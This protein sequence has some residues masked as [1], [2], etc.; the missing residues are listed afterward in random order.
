M[1]KE[2]YKAL[3]DAD[4]ERNLEITR[5]TLNRQA[6]EFLEEIL[7]WDREYPEAMALL[8]A[9]GFRT[10][11]SDNHIKLGGTIRIGARGINHIQRRL[12]K[13][14]I[15]GP[16]QYPAMLA[17][18]PEDLH[19]YVDKALHWALTKALGGSP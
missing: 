13:E 7:R 6:K 4:V 11:L 18:L 9:A 8:N 2:E 16:E 12:T 1:T 5:N 14:G 15:E 19:D 3:L 17:S 10:S